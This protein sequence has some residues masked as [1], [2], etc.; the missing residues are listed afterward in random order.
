[1]VFLMYTHLQECEVHKA[2]HSPIMGYSINLSQEPT[3]IQR[4]CTKAQHTT[5]T[6]MKCTPTYISKLEAQHIQTHARNKTKTCKG[7]SNFQSKQFKYKL[8]QGGTLD[9][10]QKLDNPID[11]ACDKKNDEFPSILHNLAKSP[12][13][14]N[15]T[16]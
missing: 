5:H 13:P 3:K 12:M 6:Y 9:I 7:A 8:P 14:S 15:N 10:R 2:H 1:M 11:L 4:R 16:Y